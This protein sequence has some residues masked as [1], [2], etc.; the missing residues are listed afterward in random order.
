M[1]SFSNI[2]ATALGSAG[3][4]CHCLIGMRT[5]LPTH[6][7]P[8]P[9]THSALPPTHSAGA[10]RTPHPGS[11]ADST[12]REPCGLICS[13]PHILISSY[14]H[15]LT[16]SYARILISSYPH[17]LSLSLS[18]SQPA[19]WPAGQP[20]SRAPLDAKCAFGAPKVQ[21]MEIFGDPALWAY[22]SD[23]S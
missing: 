16:S 8:A 13:Y 10:M 7:P 20:A 21:K 14:A 18:L 5:P 3:T 17:I 1:S 4:L 11:H 12:P 22:V 2:S 9:P 15:I 23:V 6:I 19:S